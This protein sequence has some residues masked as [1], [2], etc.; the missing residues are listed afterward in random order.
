MNMSIA[1]E[2]E[3]GRDGGHGVDG[4]VHGFVDGTFKKWAMDGE[5]K[6]WCKW[7]VG[8]HQENWRERLLYRS[9]GKK[10]KVKI[11]FIVSS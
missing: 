6:P 8:Y 7:W 9:R 11:H 5:S 4:Y 3:K 2:K 1:E 10:I